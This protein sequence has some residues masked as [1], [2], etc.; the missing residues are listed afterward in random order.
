MAGVNPNSTLFF[1][2]FVI[3]SFVNLATLVIADSQIPF[4]QIILFWKLKE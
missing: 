2:Q 4:W 1:V 3:D